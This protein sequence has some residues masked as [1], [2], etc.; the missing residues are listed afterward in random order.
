MKVYETQRNWYKANFHTHTTRSDGKWDPER[1]MAC[2]RAQGYDVLAITDHWVQGTPGE[3]DGLLVLDGAEL[4]CNKGDQAFHIVGLGM[5]RPLALD[6]ETARA[7]HEPQRLIDAID[8]AGGIAVLAHPAWSLQ[9]IDDAEKLEGLCGCE[10]M[11]TVSGPP[12]EIRRADASNFVDLAYTAGRYW[13]VFGNDDAHFYQGDQCRT[14]CMVNAREKTRE[15]ILEALRCGQ[16]Y[17]TQGPHF[18]QIEISGGKLRV[19]CEQPVSQASFYSNALWARDFHQE[20]RD[21]AF[22]YEIKP[23]ERFIRVEV[24][25]SDGKRA[26]SGAVVL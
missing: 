8:A 23:Q 17:A 6:A 15:G 4:D 2:Y 5:E 13:S 12:F 3:Q 24:T 14:W 10:I 16:F 21:T 9:R 18:T 20:R 19:E 25:D 26:W 1:V 11:N 22:E 7:K